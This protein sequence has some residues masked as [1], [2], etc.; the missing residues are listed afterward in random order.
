MR[1]GVKKSAYIEVIAI[2]ILIAVPLI[3][4]K[5]MNIIHVLHDEYG[6]W[7]AG[8][9]FA[10]LDWN[11]V[12]THSSYYSFGY[13]A[14]LS[15]FMRLF[16]SPEM[17]YKCGVVLNGL[18]LAGSY[19]LTV[20]CIKKIFRETEDT[21]A[22]IIAFVITIYSNNIIQ[23]QVVWPENLLYFLYLIEVYLIASILE[24]ASFWKIIGI[25]LCTSY[26]YMVHQRSL[27]VAV[28]IVI[29]MIILFCTKNK[30][31]KLL[32]F[33]LCF[34]GILLG[35][36]IL[37]K[38]NMISLMFSQNSHAS[39]T[40]NFSG[41]T[42]KLIE[43]FTT[44]KGFLKA[45]VGFIGKL[46][47]ICSATLG[48]AAIGIYTICKDLFYKL[49]NRHENKDFMIPM[50]LLMSL[51][52]SLGI[53]TIFM[54]KGS[55]LDCVIYGRYTEFL[56]AP[57]LIYGIINLIKN[58]VELKEITCI[59]AGMIAMGGITALYMHTM[60]TTQFN[61]IA[62]TGFSMFFKDGQSG[63]YSM[64]KW[65]GFLIIVFLAHICVYAKKSFKKRGIW[66]LLI[67][68]CIFWVATA[69]PMIKLVKDTQEAKYSVN[70]LVEQ[71][72][73]YDAENISIGY[74]TE[75]NDW[76]SREIEYIRFLL[77]KAEINY[78]TGKEKSDYSE[79]WLIANTNNIFKYL[80]KGT[81]V[82]EWGDLKLYFNGDTQK[83]LGK[84][85]NVA[86]EN[87][88]LYFNA[89]NM[90][91]QNRDKTQ[92]SWISDGTEGYLAYGPYMKLSKGK[93]KLSILVETDGNPSAK[94]KAG[95]ADIFSSGKVLKEKTI[96][97]TS[98]EKKYDLEFSVDA[99]MDAVE[100]RIYTE[101]GIKIK[102]NEMWLE[103]L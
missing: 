14:I 71:I 97:C 45:V 85:I 20:G 57:I 62:S 61:V 31:K 95:I 63:V 3:N 25:S 11:A 91:S 33:S 43:I 68:T 10:G 44:W 55:R 60:Q 66:F 80:D 28:A 73:K 19:C 87:N 23:S 12:S 54:L 88:K 1:S 49:K 39:S 98:D 86:G 34:M 56:Y 32:I 26:M 40:N 82:K 29:T 51:I 27:G 65:I 48:I 64:I 58:K 6:Y 102:V 72:Q 74:I 17:M 103:K 94:E 78:Y 89:D 41:Q 46:F 100:F 81:L 76:D 37:I 92:A 90:F 69:I 67:G 101:P 42:G 7:A 30:N 2:M 15:V 50:F 77:P 83:L 9:Y 38:S 8:A 5:S 16:D 22:C 70:T 52:F 36:Y 84:G 35:V 53:S 21:T 47:Y 99:T 75:K 4:I 79:Q 18:L 13:G 96:K 93:Y 24:R 59:F